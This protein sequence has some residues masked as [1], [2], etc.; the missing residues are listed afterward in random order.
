MLEVVR[1]H[2]ILLSATQMS[3]CAIS[4]ACAAIATGFLISGFQPGWIMLAS[5]IAF[6]LGI[7]M[8]AT[9]PVNQI[10]W[11]QTF[12][13]ASIT[14]FGMDMSFPAS[15]IVLSDSMPEEHQD[16]QLLW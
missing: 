5:M 10:Y 9:M 4:G 3:P 16:W 15:V 2:S 13:A 12:V 7:I 1:G 14:S 8:L 11:S 6:A